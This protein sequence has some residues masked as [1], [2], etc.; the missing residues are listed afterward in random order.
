MD[1][2]VEM[3]VKLGADTSGLQRGLQQ[4]SAEVKGFRSIGSGLASVGRSMTLGLTL[5]IV[6]AGIAG[7]KA[8]GDMQQSMSMFRSV[9]G[10]TAG[11]MKA[12][13]AEA[14]K[15]GNDTR[16]PGTS[17]SDAATAMLELGKG[18]MNAAQAMAAARPTLILAAAAGVDTSTAATIASDALHMFGLKAGSLGSAVDSLAG[19]ANASTAD[20]GDVAEA[21]QMTGTNA[22]Q[23]G[24][25]LNDTATAIALMANAG[26]KGSDAGTSLKT[27]LQRLIPTTDK[28]RKVLSDLGVSVF[29]STGHMRPFGD[30]VGQFSGAL[31]KLNPKQRQTAINTL[32][33]SDA[34]RAATIVLGAGRKRW[35]S[36]SASVGKAGSAQQTRQRS[37]EG[38]ER[39]APGGAKLAGNSGAVVRQGARAVNR[40][41]GRRRGRCGELVFGAR[42][43]RF[44]T[45]PRWRR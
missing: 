36:M 11:Q 39:R 17:A 14:V 8:Y 28:Q 6:A 31:D 16:L 40:Q 42:R 5:P 43:R 25:S 9:T 44:S 34:S 21:L 20:I 33:G 23:A 2:T 30:L 26:I 22:H 3:L 1:S 38:S 7:A 32:F 35:N 37:D 4:A 10:A 15:L 18:G 12:A 24:L 27:M 41:G 29:D 45:T 19:A 13:G